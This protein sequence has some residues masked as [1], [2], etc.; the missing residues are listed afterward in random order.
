M[1]PPRGKRIYGLDILR[2]IAILL[3]LLSHTAFML[4]VTNEYQSLLFILCGFNGVEIFFVLSGYLIGAILLRLGK[5][6]EF[7]S[8][9]IK[10]FWIR[11][12]FRTLPVYYLAL[13]LNCGLYFYLY[14]DFIFFHVYNLLFLI[15][16]QNFLAVHP[17]FF[18]EAWSLSIEEF[19][20]LIVPL[21]FLTLGRFLN[22]RSTFFI[23]IGWLIA[24]TLLRTVIVSIYNPIW[25]SGVRM[26]V[27]LRMDSLMTGVLFAWVDLKFP[28]IWKQ[29]RTLFLFLGFLLLAFSLWW[30][31]FD[32]IDTGINAGF[33]SKTFLF[34][35]FSFGFAFCLP[36]FSGIYYPDNKYIFRSIT[37][38]SMV[39]Y[40]LYLTHSIT[41]FCFVAMCNKLNILKGSLVRFPFAWIFCILA[42]SILYKLY[43]KPMMDIREKFKR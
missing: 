19:F 43:E 28:G 41:L 42:A 31:K 26:I 1:K 15:F 10:S 20:Y 40:S 6:H 9:K 34:N 38:I 37:H 32:V 30:F 21:T 24:S 18:R 14:H 17:S 36:F 5:N 12:W 2:T 23:I 4:P 3:V 22:L 33:F 11:R 13:V 27:P 25:D 8:G 7:T 35:L 16:F 29:Y 39:S